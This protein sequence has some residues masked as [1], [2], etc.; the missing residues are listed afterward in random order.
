MTKFRMPLLATISG[1]VFDFRR[2]RRPKK[3]IAGR[4]YRLLITLDLLQKPGKALHAAVRPVS[5]GD[6]V[7]VHPRATEFSPVSARRRTRRHERKSS[8]RCNGAYEP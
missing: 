3:G 7:R 6:I 5:D 2:A 4:C 8:S 1:S